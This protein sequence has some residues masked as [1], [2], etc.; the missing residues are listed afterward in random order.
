MPTHRAKP[1]S[2]AAFDNLLASMLHGDPHARFAAADAAEKASRA[3]PALLAAH[4]TILLGVLLEFGQAGLRWHLLQMLPR[5]ELDPAARRRVF[6]VACRWMQD[7]S[8]I[9]ASEALTAMFALSEAGEDLRDHA[10]DTARRLLASPSPALR[11]RARKC[12]GVGR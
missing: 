4:K 11:A 9:V 2:Q 3:Q 7:G 12:M 1:I 6:D 5:L 8:R 10:L